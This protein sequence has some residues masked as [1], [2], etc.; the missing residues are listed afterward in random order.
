MNKWL[1][2]IFQIWKMFAIEIYQH[3]QHNKQ[4]KCVFDDVRWVTVV[5]SSLWHDE[6]FCV[7][8]TEIIKSFQFDSMLFISR[9]LIQNLPTTNSRR[10]C[11]SI[12]TGVIFDLNPPDSWSWSIF[13]PTISF[14]FLWLNPIKVTVWHYGE[15]FSL[16][17]SF[18]NLHHFLRRHQKCYWIERN[19]NAANDLIEIGSF[20]NTFK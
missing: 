4:A 13:L 9:Y 6:H 2:I 10:G 20:T 5:W 16:F 18:R 7:C 8:G 3:T 12:I 11:G 1:K 14:L 17:G 15:L 19:M